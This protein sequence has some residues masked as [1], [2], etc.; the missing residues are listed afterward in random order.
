MGGELALAPPGLLLVS[1]PGDA[2]DDKDDDDERDVD[3]RATW[4]LRGES[5]LAMTDAKDVG[6]PI[7]FTSTGLRGQTSEEE[8]G[9]FI[10]F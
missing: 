8:A 7:V 4:R 1:P 10:G 9:S 3:F 2:D 6:M 5:W